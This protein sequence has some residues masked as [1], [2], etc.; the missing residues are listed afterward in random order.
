M[1]SG[2]ALHEAERSGGKGSLAVRYEDSSVAWTTPI[3]G[4]QQ[5]GAV[6]PAQPLEHSHMQ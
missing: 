4:L 6:V 1:K 2:H 3:G 5:C